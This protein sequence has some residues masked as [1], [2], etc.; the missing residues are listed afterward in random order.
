M[1]AMAVNSLLCEAIRNFVAGVIGNFALMSAKPKPLAQTSSWSLT[2]PTATPG[3]P[4]IRD[5]PFD[6]RG[7]EALG[8]KDLR[9]VGDIC[10]VVLLTGSLRLK[11]SR[12]E[13]RRN[14]REH[15]NAEDDTDHVR[16]S[17]RRRLR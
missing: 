15:G 7:K 11:G 6:P 13:S 14:E 9:I 4:L 16:A 12:L 8:P 1:I 3:I 5:L 10:T 2:T 17:A